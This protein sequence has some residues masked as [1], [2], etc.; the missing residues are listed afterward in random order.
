M[1]NKH[2]KMDSVDCDELIYGG[3]EWHCLRYRDRIYNSETCYQCKF[4][5]LRAREKALKEGRRN[6]KIL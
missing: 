2:L 1:G 4:E 3:H 6:G 5:E